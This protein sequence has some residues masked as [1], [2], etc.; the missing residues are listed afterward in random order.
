MITNYQ[1][2]WVGEMGLPQKWGFKNQMP[3]FN[4]GVKAVRIAF[5]FCVA[6]CAMN[7]R[8]E[9]LVQNGNWMPCFDFYLQ[10][11]GRTIGPCDATAANG[12]VRDEAWR[13]ACF[14]KRMSQLC[15]YPPQ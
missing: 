7:E 4:P 15:S 13:N 3:K 11:H 2:T 8:N 10:P 9:I 1:A 12:T 14:D 5:R 6:Y